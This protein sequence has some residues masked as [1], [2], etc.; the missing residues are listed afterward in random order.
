MRLPWID[1]YVYV[2]ELKFGKS[3]QEALDQINERSYADAF[4]VKGKEIVKVGIS[5][6]V[7][8]GANVVDW[9]TSS[10]TG[11]SD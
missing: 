11:V 2:M 7:K 10:G 4:A 3:A 9:V 1:S 6:G 8:D 5:F